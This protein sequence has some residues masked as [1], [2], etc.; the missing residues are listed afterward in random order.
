[1]DQ[2]P[3]QVKVEEKVEGVQEEPKK[4][5]SPPLMPLFVG[6]SRFYTIGAALSK[7]LHKKFTHTYARTK[8]IDR[9]S[10]P[11]EF[12][13]WLAWFTTQQ[14]RAVGQMFKDK[15]GEGITPEKLFLEVFGSLIKVQDSVTQVAEEV[16]AEQTVTEE[17]SQD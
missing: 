1:M 12:S 17:K 5:D 13:A 2:Q 8:D 15:L 7:D 6:D 4:E 14:L 3:E 10:Y 9:R 11:F 16:Q